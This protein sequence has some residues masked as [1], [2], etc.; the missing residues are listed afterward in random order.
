MRDAAFEPALSAWESGD[1][2]AAADHCLVRLAQAP[3]HAGSHYILGLVAHRLGQRAA[4]IEL[5]GQAHALDRAEATYLYALGV[6]LLEDGR[7]DTAR[8]CFENAV[9][10][11]PD[12][13]SAHNNLGVTLAG[14]DPEAAIACFR[15]AIARDAGLADP[16]YN[17]AKALRGLG[18]LDEA[19]DHY[20]AALALQPGLAAAHNNLGIALQQQ[21]RLDEAIAAY[22]AALE[23]APALADAH[24]N[25]GT[26]LLTA[27]DFAAGFAAYEWRWHTP[28]LRDQRRPAL[29]PAWDGA[30]GTGGTLLIQAEQG[31]GDTLQF[32]RLVPRAAARGWRVV[33]QVQ[34]PLV[35]LLQGLADQV[36]SLADPA[37]PCDAQLP[38]LSLPHR[39]GLTPETIPAAPYLT[40]PPSDW[41]HKLPPG[42]RV[43]LAWAGN[44]RRDNAIFAAVD[45]RRSIDPALLAPLASLPGIVLVS[46]QKSGPPAPFPVIDPMP[47]MHDLADTAALI[48]ALDLVITVDTA[49]AH[50]AGALGRPVWLLNRFDTCWRWGLNRT[51]SPWYPTLTIHRQSTAGAWPP[52]IATVVALLGRKEVRPGGSAPWT[53]AREA[54]GSA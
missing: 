7:E 1:L 12:F 25:L 23:I 6:V 2:Q 24:Y 9:I 16:H 31:L 27:G 37:P 28:Q 52:V 17:L 45:A 47:H 4:A 51:D 50:L 30:A 21:N 10:L 36:M 22:R 48:A 20:R 44:P 41:A 26:A 29:A 40:A 3:A 42:R 5:L 34:P 13:A 8:Q 39:L 46:L 15:R 49:I 35:R 54:P 32:C 11:A 18:R 38:L 14:T 19:I 53:P 33:L 43:G